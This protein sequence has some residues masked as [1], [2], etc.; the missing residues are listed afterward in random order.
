MVRRP[1]ST[2]FF[3]VCC[4]TPEHDSSGLAVLVDLES[5]R[6]CVIDGTSRT[7]RLLQRR[8]AF[9]MELPPE[10]EFSESEFE[11]AGLLYGIESRSVA[12]SAEG[13]VENAEH[14]PQQLQ[15]TVQ[16]SPESSY[17]LSNSLQN[18]SE[19]WQAQTP[20]PGVQRSTATQHSTLGEGV[21]LQ[22]PVLPEKGSQRWAN[23][24]WHAHEHTVVQ[25]EQSTDVPQ[26][27]KSMPIDLTAGVI[28]KQAN[29]DHQKRFRER[30]KVCSDMHLLC[31]LLIRPK[32][33]DRC[34]A[35][36]WQALQAEAHALRS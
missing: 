11:Q 36:R 9:S 10:I 13:H 4:E 14:Q 1:A 6:P 35:E 28:R 8:E 15:N 29:R 27:Y 2:A 17:G 12:P 16:S 3:I 32:Q 5:L 22:T 21:A 23:L 24:H 25:P 33:E 34:A 31:C 19:P 18:P 20:R 7:P 30:Q 26:H